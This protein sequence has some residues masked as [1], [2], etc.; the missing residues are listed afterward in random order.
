M[1]KKRRAIV[2]ISGPNLPKDT[3][4]V[5]NEGIT[6]GRLA[7]VGF[8]L[9]DNK[10]SRQ[11][12]RFILT[13]Q[14]LTVQDL[15]S[16]NGTFYNDKRLDPQQPVLLK[17]GDAVIIGPFILTFESLLE[18]AEGAAKLSDTAEVPLSTGI[19][20][21]SKDATQ[22][23]ED[24]AKVTD[25]EIQV[26]GPTLGQ[27]ALSAPP[28]EPEKTDRPTEEADIA[29]VPAPHISLP[30]APSGTPEPLSYTPRH[31][32]IVRIQSPET[33]EVRVE[34]SFKGAVAG[35]LEANEIPLRH[36]RVSRQNTR[37]VMTTTSLMVEDLNSSNGTY[38]GEERLV[39]M[40]P[41]PVKIGDVMR[42]GPFTL[43]LEKIIEPMEDE[44]PPLAVKLDLPLSKQE[45][46]DE[47]A[48]GGI[49]A[50]ARMPGMPHLPDLPPDLPRDLGHPP[51]FIPPPPPGAFTN[52]KLPKEP[53]LKGVPT[54]AS[55]YLQ[56][57]PGVFSEDEML[58]RFL[59]IPES[60]NAPIEWLI[61]NFDMFLDARYTPP[62]WLQWF[63]SWFDVFIPATLPVERQRK[64]VQELPTLFLY[65]GTRKSLARHLELVFGVEPTIQEP[66]DAP[67]TFAV[68]L[69]LN[70]AERLEIN[71]Q[72]AERIIESQRPAHTSYTLTI[73]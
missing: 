40:Q 6:L 36:S 35:R 53:P 23:I 3:I 5:T 21:L 54:R 55:S 27:D 64:I 31:V 30:A 9:R 66:R 19:S 26:E 60:I 69:A 1:S 20:S 68:T 39:P 61:D 63:G 32:A 24:P 12:A 73:T 67:A 42:I 10:I 28:A 45:T 46:F 47:T 50:P 49:I 51:P 38:V 7:D 18:E 29:E 25:D 15:G 59:L 43:T 11:H 44:L 34:I 56:Y 71:Q 4:E 2:R 62:D 17:L 58:G 57:L 37:F 22:E 16:S 8:T 70:D 14:G 72:I 52:G 65:R 13:A 41:Y 33:N 48:V